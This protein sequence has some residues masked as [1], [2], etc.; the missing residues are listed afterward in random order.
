MFRA[1]IGFGEAKLKR[2]WMQLPEPIRIDF[3][4][5]SMGRD[6]RIERASK[7]VSELGNVF[8]DE[9]ARKAM[10]AATVVYSVE[11][12]KPVADNTAG[13]LFW[14]NSTV[15]P[16][17]VGEEYF[18]TRG[19]FH[20]NRDRAEYYAT[21]SG[22]GLLVLMDEG[23]KSSMQ[24]M[25]AGTTH[26]VP[27]GFAHRVVNTGE[28]PLTFLACWPSDAGYDYATIDKHGFSVRVFRRNGRPEV[29]AQS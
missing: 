10:D 28:V 29:V 2:R 23:R 11:Y 20:A 17:M 14:G 21:V 3:T 24:Q 5:G 1:S 4:T 22:N 27:G 15:L 18:M 6:A 12:W 25:E 16:G 26:Y 7:L 13:G 8:L 9:Q 19:H